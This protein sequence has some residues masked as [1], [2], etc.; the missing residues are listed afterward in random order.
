LPLILSLSKDDGDGGR[1]NA[2]PGGNPCNKTALERIGVKRRQN[3]AQM[4]MGRRAMQKRQKP[5]QKLQLLLAKPGNVTN[6]LSA[7]Q[8][9]RQAKKQNLIQGTHH[10][11]ALAM[12]RQILEM[13]KKYNNLRKVQTIVH[14]NPSKTNQRNSTDSAL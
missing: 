7:S 2:E 4:V 14:R 8:N 13:I 6:R 9:R 1:R 12:I 10:L 11:A 5:A 3:V